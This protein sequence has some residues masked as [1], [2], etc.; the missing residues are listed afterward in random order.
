MR[1]EQ[2]TIHPTYA[3]LGSCDRLGR[4]LLLLM[5]V[6]LLFFWPL[7]GSAIP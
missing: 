5:L 1:G 4:M 3:A 7:A 6:L 2:N